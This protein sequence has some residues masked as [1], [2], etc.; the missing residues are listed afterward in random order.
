MPFP[1]PRLEAYVVSLDRK[2][3]AVSQSHFLSE[4]EP[5]LKSEKSMA[6]S[7]RIIH[8]TP[9]GGDTKYIGEE[10]NF[11][12]SP[13]SQGHV[14]THGL[15]IV[16][17]GLLIVGEMAGS[18]IL[19]IPK[20]LVDAGWSGVMLL[21]ICCVIS[22]YCGIILGKCWTILRENNAVYRDFPRDPYPSIGYECYGRV[23]RGIVEF[24]LLVTLFGACTVY[25]LLSAQNVAS[26][27]DVKIAGYTTETSEARI[28]LLVISAG[29]L[30]FTFLGTPK[31][32]WPFAVFATISTA[33]ACILIIVKSGLDW[34]SDISK[35]PVEAITVDSFFGAFGTIAF[36][37]GGATLFPSFQTDMKEPQNFP[38]AAILAFTC[39]FSLYCPTSIMPFMVYGASMNS[40]VLQTI[41]HQGDT[42]SVKNLAIAAEVLITAHLVFSFVIILNPISQQV[43]EY[44]KWPKSKYRARKIYFK[45][46]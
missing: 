8:E 28:W 10:C 37:F 24:C 29:L 4:R 32:I 13:S 31:D 5:I 17:C 44:L 45:L 18:G 40:N 19:A 36:A 41:K 25:L 14:N 12:G 35:V 6:S 43:E 27:V 22:L 2:V 46:W 23:G 42:G 1:M 15:T 20:A 30:P 26:L 16:T 9:D 38:K 21:A 7:T 34:P 33:I 3:L 11:S 39:V